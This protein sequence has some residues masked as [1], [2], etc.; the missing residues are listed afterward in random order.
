[1]AKGM[2][3]EDNGASYLDLPICRV[4]VRW[5]DLYYG[6]RYTYLTFESLKVYQDK[7]ECKKEAI[8]SIRKNLEVSLSF[9]KE[10]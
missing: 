1:M 9:V 5:A 6:Y 2:W 4:S 10:G 8:R 3:V 7:E